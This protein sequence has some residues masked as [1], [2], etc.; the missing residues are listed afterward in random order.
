MS[1]VV[2]SLVS[3]IC[4]YMYIYDLYVALCIILL[5]FYVLPIVV[6]FLLG[7]LINST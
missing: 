5:G 6:Y 4:I 3:N 2:Q 7:I 1:D